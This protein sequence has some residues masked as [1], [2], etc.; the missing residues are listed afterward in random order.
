MIDLRRLQV[1]LA[2]ADTGSFTAAAQRLFLSQ[3]G[4]SQQIGLLER[5][6]GEPLFVRTARGVR[7]NEAGM[8]LRDRARGLID[9]TFALE[10]D[11]RSQHEDV[12]RVT[13]GAFPSAG[14]ELLPQ[15]F[16]RLLVDWPN[17]RLQLKQLDAVDP[18]SLLRDQEADVVLVFEYDIA[19]RP[20]DHEFV[21]VELADDPLCVL[22][23]EGHPLA[24]AD[25]VDL[26]DLAGQTWVLRRHRPPYERIHEQ[27]FRRAGVEATIAFWTDDYQSLQGLVAAHVGVS[28]APSLSITQH[29]ADIVVRP[30]GHP[31]F[32]RRVSLVMSHQFANRPVADAL[33]SA[34]RTAAGHK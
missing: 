7:L 5:E 8:F 14:V 27:M 24:D 34:M 32:T 13:I 4:V 16:R 33:V 19:P 20:A 2:V 31:R 9:Q 3:P 26:T 15:A 21:H 6:L 18:L 22:L 30:L 17:L 25:A 23:P 10:R 28:I 11:F 12:T 1:F 29:R